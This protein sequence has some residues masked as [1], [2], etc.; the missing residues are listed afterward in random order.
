MTKRSSNLLLNLF[1]IPGL[2]QFV[3]GRWKLGLAFLLVEIALLGWA[4]YL[5]VVFMLNALAAVSSPEIA[6]PVRSLLKAG[7]KRLIL[8]VA[9]MFVNRAVSG[10]EAYVRT[11]DESV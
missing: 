3:E 6:E 9:L 4:I 10:I 7:A 1:V 5:V 8:P 11:R 2:G